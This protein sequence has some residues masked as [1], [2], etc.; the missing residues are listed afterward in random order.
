VSRSTELSFTGRG[1]RVP[2]QGAV[3]HGRVTRVL[4]QGAVTHG[5]GTRV[6]DQEAVTHGSQ[7]WTHSICQSFLP[8]WT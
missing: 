8:L 5:R 6:P 4:E 2:E 3:I 7:L 1:A